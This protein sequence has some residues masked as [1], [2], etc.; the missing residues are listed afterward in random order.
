MNKT[1]DTIFALATPIG[2]SAVATIRV[3]G[4]T[5]LEAVNKISLNMPKKHATAKVNTIIS[6][7]KEHID[8]TIT[9]IFKSP[10]TY[11]GEDVVEISSHGG[12]AVINKIIEV[13]GRRCRLRLAEPG[14]FTRRAFENNKL[15]LTQVEAISDLVNSET[16]AQRKQA[17]SQ[18]SGLFSGK[19]KK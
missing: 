5:A 6:S 14:E 1:K 8:Q 3:S 2:R 4:S 10:N 11:T 9:T 18:L 19:I 12:P 16:E 7:N 15:D 17:V 13:L